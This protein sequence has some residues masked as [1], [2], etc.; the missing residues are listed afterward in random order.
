M[1]AVVG[2]VLLGLW[3]PVPPGGAV[4]RLAPAAQVSPPAPSAPRAGSPDTVPLPDGRYLS[5]Q[6]V[7]S[8]TQPGP[9]ARPIPVRT[10]AVV[11][12]D[13]RREDGQV[14][15]DSRYCALRQDAIGRV[16]TVL[17]STFLSTLPSWREPATIEGTGP[18]RVRVAEHVAVVGARLDDPGRDAL[19]EREDDGRIT[20]PDG[21]GRPGV[22]VRVEGFVS[23]EVYL[24]Q[25]I[26]R[27]L[28]GTLETD[29]RMRGRVLGRNEQRTIGASNLLLKAFTP[30]FE[31]DPDPARNTFEWAPLPAGSDCAGAEEWEARLFGPLD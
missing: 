29:G 3:I 20:D 22:T 1:N 5:R 21:D 4:V 8:R 11:L 7:T 25:R 18:W 14:F 2:S 16:R 26:V 23:G 28:D 6:V 17:D 9:R 10:I 15:V 30:T 27:S 31:P 19:P 12:H 13:V 24:V